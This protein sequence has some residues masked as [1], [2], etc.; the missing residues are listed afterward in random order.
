MLV[1]AAPGGVGI[2]TMQ[3][4][5]GRGARVIAA[6]GGAAKT[7]VCRE[8][9]AAVTV[10]Y[11]TA[12]LTAAVLDATAAGGVDVVVEQVGGPVFTRLLDLRR[13]RGT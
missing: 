7:A 9:G 12:D 2:A 4:A 11:L 13:V 10:D 3:L 6:A 1:T 8:Q 5:V